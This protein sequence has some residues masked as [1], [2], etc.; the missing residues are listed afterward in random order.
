MHDVGE[1]HALQGDLIGHADVIEQ[2]GRVEVAH[3]IIHRGP[4]VGVAH[5]DPDVGANQFVTDP[6]GTQM[7]DFYFGN[8]ERRR[9]ATRVLRQS[10][11]HKKSAEAKQ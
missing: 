3:V 2:T 10:E 7:F 5:L 8:L 11:E 6:G 9:L 1:R 4:Q